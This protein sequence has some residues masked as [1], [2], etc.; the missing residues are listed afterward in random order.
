MPFYLISGQKVELAVLREKLSK[1]DHAHVQAI[2]E[3]IAT[4]PPVRNAKRYLLTALY[5][6]DMAVH[7]N[8]L[9]RKGGQKRNSFN[10]FHQRNY[11]YTDLERRL[12]GWKK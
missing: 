3:G 10:N 2:L 1:L 7:I 6:S 12:L 8:N 9:R 11:D 5:Q 4:G